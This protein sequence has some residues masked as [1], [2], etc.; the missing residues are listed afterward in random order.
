MTKYGT[1]NP[2]LLLVHQQTIE[3]SLADFKCGRN[4]GHL[5]A[6]EVDQVIRA[7]ETRL[8]NIK[9]RLTRVR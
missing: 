2:G 5:A 4:T 3:R 6:A 7:L 9:D 1:T 8:E